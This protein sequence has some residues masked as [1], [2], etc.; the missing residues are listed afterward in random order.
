MSAV[1]D[2]VVVFVADLT[3]AMER[4]AQLGFTVVP[5]GV[6]ASGL[7][8]NAIVPFADGSYVEL[9]GFTRPS[10]YADMRDA[11]ANGTMSSAVAGKTPLDQRFLP[12]A[13]DGVGLAD[14]AIGCGE[15]DRV[16]TRARDE[17]LPVSGP[18]PGSRRKP[19]GSVIAWQLV[20]PEGEELPF[21]IEDVTP[22]TDR[23]PV[24]DAHY[25]A[26]RI[27]GIHEVRYHTSSDAPFLLL[28][29]ALGVTTR[30]DDGALVLALASGC[31]RI[32]LDAKGVVRPSGV[33]FGF[34]DG[35]EEVW[36][37]F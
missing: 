12:R 29:Q 18:M 16:I 37:D 11:R 20:F 7:T 4:Y 10:Q 9:L 31:L 23:V 1:L 5:G 15:V 14:A 30:I 6:H 22:R 34:A 25:H 13:A 21:L 35:R 24:V 32:T 36:D 26:N 2:H 33:V 8:H 27:V 28:A 17:G 19:D 3:E